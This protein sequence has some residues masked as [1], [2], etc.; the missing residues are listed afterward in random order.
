MTCREFERSLNELVDAEAASLGDVL[1]PSALE[2]VVSDL[3][4]ALADHA[5][6]C[7]ACRVLAARHQ[8][9]RRAVHA[10]NAPP[11]APADLTDRILA[12]AAEERSASAWAVYGVKPESYRPII[13]A[14]VSA[15]AACLVGMVMLHLVVS[16]DASQKPAAPP[17]IANLAHQDLHTGL[18]PST[19]S[20]SDVRELQTAM[21]DATAATWEL[22]RSASEPTARISREML[23]VA[24]D[25]E[26]ELTRGRSSATP[27]S[28][29]ISVTM[30]SLSELAPDPSST[31]AMLQEVSDRLASGVRPLSNTARHAFSFLLGPA[32]GKPAVRGA[33]P[34]ASAKGA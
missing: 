15:M 32:P 16:R 23:D 31:S 17:V 33:R 22:A 18:W 19:P 4:V 2:S 8:V 9:F 27:S 5:G 14:Y 11:V 1:A 30:P 26:A 12:A 3:D 34:S 28:P 24:T 21:A 7:P 29:A 20:H 10:W 25:R 6:R 13:V